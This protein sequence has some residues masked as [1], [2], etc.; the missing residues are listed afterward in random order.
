MITNQPVVID[1]GSGVL[2]A[3]FA[4][5]DKPKCEFPSFVGTPKHKRVMAGA[6]EG[7]N[8]VGNK[9][10]EHRGLMKINYAM[11]HGVVTRWDDMERLWKQV[12]EELSA[13]SSEHPVLLTEAP[14]NPRKNREKAA[15]IF[16]DVFSSP[17]VFFSAQAVLSL[18]ASGR[19]TGVVLD[20]GDGVSH[21]VPVY[22]GFA[23]QN[24]IQRMDVAGRDVTEYLQILLRRAGYV[25]HTSAE[26]EVVRQVK[27]AACYVAFNPVEEELSYLSRP[28]ALRNAGSQKNAVY[29]LPDGKTIELGAECFRAPEILFQPDLVG[30]EY[31]GIHQI[32]A[33]SIRKT[34][35]D[36]RASL[37][38]NVVLAGGST[39]FR[40]FG[41]RLLSELKSIAPA[42]IKL[43]I[44][45]PQDRK[46]STWVGGSILASLTT[47]RQM[48]VSK[49]QYAEYGPSF[50]H[51]KCF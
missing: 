31:E 32:L 42:D 46:Y 26:L 27:E 25:F 19:T 22:E 13:D 34:D 49:E 47:F 21:A 18:Y 10:A 4:G 8:F 29:K 41:D 43:K 40:G 39:M 36:L 33:R 23:V 51:K 48:W 16:F 38:S 44:L 9:A 14:L 45:A 3:G 1:N 20:S 7:D 5:G 12:Y 2:K 24:A 37:Y 28:H 6:L 11:E 15:E 30:Y 17:A 35:L 50:L